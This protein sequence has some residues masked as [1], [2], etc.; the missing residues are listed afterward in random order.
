MRENIIKEAKLTTLFTMLPYWENCCRIKDEAAGGNL[1]RKRD[2]IRLTY[3]QHVPYNVF[4]SR[5]LLPKLNTTV[6]VFFRGAGM[7]QW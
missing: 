7:V 3:T 1:I 6:E 4:D 2:M 5:A